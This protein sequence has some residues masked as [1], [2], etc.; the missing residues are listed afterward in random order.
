M[1][2]AGAVVCLGGLVIWGSAVGGDA[3]QG[4]ALGGAGGPREYVGSALTIVNSFGFLITVFSIQLASSLLP[5]IGAR[6]IFWLLIP[7]P[8]LGLLAMRPLLKGSPD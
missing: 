2:S 5:V 1:F 4:S 8:I 7:G 6:Y 3:R